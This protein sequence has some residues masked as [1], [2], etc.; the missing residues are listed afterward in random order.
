[1]LFLAEA[2]TRPKMMAA[3]AKAGFSQSYTYFTWRNTKAELIDYMTELTALPERDFFR[4]NFFPSTPDILPKFLQTDNPAAFR[5]RAALAAML[6]GSYGIYSGFELCEGT[7]IPGTEEYLNSEKYEIKVRDWNAPGN[8]KD[9]IRRLNEM[10]R[11]LPA[12]QTHLGIRF[13]DFADES[14]LFFAKQAPGE[15][16]VVFV[17]I[18]LDPN[19]WADSWIELPLKDYGLDNM[20]KLKVVDAFHNASWTIENPWVQVTLTP[21]NPLW[22]RVVGI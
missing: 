5:I 15:S 18:L 12:L 17:A 1:V 9:F 6:S 20:G 13:H 2:F 21:D 8:I 16:K 3:L 10:R 4:P 22:V 7:P 14:V 11:S 19:A